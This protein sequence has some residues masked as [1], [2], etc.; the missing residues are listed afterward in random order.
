M[1]FELVDYVD[2]VSQDRTWDFSI[3][4]GF[5]K[6]VD[7]AEADFQRAVVA[8]FMQRGTFPQMAGF[9]NQWAETLTGQVAPQILNAQVRESIASVTGGMRYMPK[10]SMSNGSLLVEVKAV[11]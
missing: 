10:Y 2:P 4:D 6:W 8:T 9:G 5:L 1:D 7:H 3:K 11:E